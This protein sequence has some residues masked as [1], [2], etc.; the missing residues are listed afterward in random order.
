M[1]REYSYEDLVK[2]AA[3]RVEEVFKK[4]RSV[5]VLAG[6]GSSRLGVAGRVPDSV[7]VSY[8]PSGGSAELLRFEGGEP[9][10]GDKTL[11]EYVR[12]KSP[13]RV[14]VVPESTIE[15]IRAYRSLS[16]K[17]GE[18]KVALVFTP[19]IYEEELKRSDFKPPEEAEVDCSAVFKVFNVKPEGGDKGVSLKLLQHHGKGEWEELKKGAAALRALSPGGLTL[20]DALRRVGMEVA[21]KLGRGAAEQALTIGAAALA[22]VIAMMVGGLPGVVALAAGYLFS[23]SLL[24]DAAEDLIRAGSGAPEREYPERLAEL[25]RKA[26]IAAQFVSDERF[27]GVAD[28]VASQWGLSLRKFRNFVE[29]LHRLTGGR[30]VTEEELEKLLKQKVGELENRVKELEKELRQVAGSAALGSLYFDGVPGVEL[31]DGSVRLSIALLTGT[32]TVGYVP[33]PLEEKVAYELR[34]AARRGGGVVVVKGG[35][36][37]GK[38]TAASVALAKLLR[39]ALPTESKEGV[40]AL[41]PVILELRLQSVDKDRLKK[42][43]EKARKT[44]FLPILYLDPSRTGHYPSTP[45]EA[46]VPEEGFAERLSRAIEYLRG[47]QGAVSLVVLSNDQYSL[48]EGKLKDLAPIDADEV[49]G[50]AKKGFVRALVEAYSGC[51]SRV[52]E[53]LAELVAD[54][55]GENYAVVAV[56]AADWLGKAGCDEGRVLEAIEHSKGK[57][58]EFVRSYL[59]YGLLGE[60]QRERSD[61]AWL[62]APLILATCLL[63]PFP[64]GLAALLLESFGRDPHRAESHAAFLWLTQPLHP[65]L[66]EVLEGMAEEA[67]ECAYGSKVCDHTG[68]DPGVIVARLRDIIKKEKLGESRDEAASSIIK[69]LAEKAREFKEEVVRDIENYGE[70]FATLVGLAHALPS[71]KSLLKEADLPEDFK[72]WLTIG[73]EMPFSA[74]LFLVEVAPAFSDAVNPCQVL[75]SAHQRAEKEKQYAPDLL[76]TALGALTISRG[77]LEGC[78]DEAA[79]A[80]GFALRSIPL[81]PERLALTSISKALMGL[82]MKLIEEGRWLE[83][84]DVAHSASMREP[85]LASELLGIVEREAGG[86]DRFDQ[87]ARTLYEDAHY[88]ARRTLRE[89]LEEWAGRVEAFLSGLR[90]DAVGLNARALLGARLAYANLRMGSVREA[91][92]WAEEAHRALEQLER[93]DRRELAE[94]LKPLLKVKYPF[95]KPEEAAERLLEELKFTVL[96]LGI[97]FRS[98]EILDEVKQKTVKMSEMFE[99]SRGNYKFAIWALSSRRIPDVGAKEFFYLNEGKIEKWRLAECA[100]P[101]LTNARYAKWFTFTEEDWEELRKRSIACYLFICH[102]PWHELPKGVQDYIKWG[103]TECR[104]QVKETRGGGKICSQALACQE[105][106]RH[107]NLFYGWYDLGG[108]EDAPILAVYQSRYK[109]RFI[110]NQKRVVT[111]HAMIAFIPK[112]NVKL[113]ERQLKALLAYLNSSFSQ[114]YIESRGRTTG[115][116]LVCLE[117]SHAREMPVIDPRTLD[118]EALGEL[119]AL[120]DKLEGAAREMGGAD[121]YENLIRLWDSVIA[122]IDRKVA[123][124]LGLAEVLADTARELAKAMMERRLARTKELKPNALKGHKGS[125]SFVR[126]RAGSRKREGGG[127]A[128]SRRLTDFL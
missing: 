44:G 12:E 38:S 89:G 102:K 112:P 75:K 110:L 78:L 36:G 47:V 88:Y 76:L 22:S 71:A 93:L 29:N 90:E 125:S 25:L 13:A 101:A 7:V 108:V 48:A 58:E 123:E 124:I 111:Y 84:V 127:A 1:S 41:S 63:G 96:N 14:I 20:A 59:W 61:E 32:G 3:E 66:L 55:F 4:G 52:A 26:I 33:N 17:L 83:A 94:S 60:D 23:P 98:E 16:E 49:L 113:D 97:I 69:R 9:L 27:E 99:V 100:Y 42:F 122:D 116:G 67:L 117:V 64:M 114:L 95:S 126:R 11:A 24:L 118:D 68:D 106:T 30:V 91:R 57:I 39:D 19:R 10:A 43:A 121:T 109:T 81:L 21:R 37:V 128:G 18:D 82:A 56:L 80:T 70:S 72:R 105:R 31:E 85:R 119:S 51:D 77:G 65:S 35:K 50:E 74:R 54:G 46:Y 15:A 73:G 79:P 45:G 92:E 62:L 87:L 104:T 115:L 2:R 8:K 107:K 120:F 86:L 53:E 34:E 103:E 28:E 6:P 40:E 5:V